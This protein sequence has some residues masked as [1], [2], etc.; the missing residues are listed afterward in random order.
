MQF[1]VIDLYK[2]TVK[3]N[4]TLYIFTYKKE[5]ETFIY[6]RIPCRVNTK[7]SHL[8]THVF[9]ADIRILNLTKL[10]DRGI[11]PEGPV[12]FAIVNMRDQKNA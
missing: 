9:K 10:W 2:Y 7:Y 6:K 12:K 5:Q 11:I 4:C 3:Q 1:V 8:C